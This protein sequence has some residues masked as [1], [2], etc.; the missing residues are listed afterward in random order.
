MKSEL[1]SY[2]SKPLPPFSRGDGDCTAFAA[3]WANVQLAKADKPTIPIQKKTFGQVSREL[4]EK[5]LSDRVGEILKASGFKVQ[6]K[7]KDGDLAVIESEQAEF[8][9]VTVGLVK[10][11]AVVV[12]GADGLF[13]V[14]DP[15]F[16]NAWH[17]SSSQA[18]KR[19][20][21]E[22]SSQD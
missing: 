8:G 7:P 9:G 6:N 13:I 22:R 21:S 3:G 5:S 16:L 1:E 10:E 19:S 20:S 2:L 4:R 12:R 11:G 17:F 15:V 14:A 18:S